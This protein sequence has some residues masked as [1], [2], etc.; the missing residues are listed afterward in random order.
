MRTFLRSRAVLVPGLVAL[1]LAACGRDDPAPTSTTETTSPGAP[2]APALSPAAPDPDEPTDPNATSRWY[3]LV[4]NGEKVGFLHVVWRPSTWNGKPTVHDTTRQVT[5][6]A[7]KMDRVED[8]FVVES[9]SDLER[10][11]DGTYW[12]SRSVTTEGARES[13]TEVTWTGDGYDQVAKVGDGEQRRRVET[14]EPVSVDAETLVGPRVVAGVAKAGDRFDLRLLNFAGSRVDVHQVEV[15]GPAQ[16]PGLDGPVATT[17]VRERDPK[18][19]HETLLWIDEQGAIAQLK[20]LSTEIRRVSSAQAKRWPSKVASFSITLPAQPPL[21]R[22]FS[23]DETQIEVHVSPDADRPRPEFPESRFSRETSVEGSD[24]KGWVVRATLSDLDAPFATAT[25]PVEDERFAKHLEP[26]AFMPCAHPDV[27]GAAR[28]A[29]GD[30]TDARR[31]AAAISRFVFT[32]LHKASSDVAQATALEILEQQRGDCSE[33]ALLFVA[34]CRAVGVPARVC[35]GY[36]CVGELWGAH[37]WAEVWTG[38]WI[39]VDPT[40]DDVGTAARYLFFGYSDDP[41]SHP[42]IVTARARGRL[43]IVTTRVVEGAEE[44][45]LRDAGSHRV[46]DE[47]AGTASHRLAGIEMRGI[48][49]GWKVSLRGAGGATIRADGWTASVRVIADQG[50]RDLSRF[51]DGREIRFAGAKAVR[52]DTR[53]GVSIRASSRRRLV[54]VDVALRAGAEADEVVGALERVLAKTFALR[55]G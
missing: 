52:E 15:V 28:R 41:D 12:W 49:A 11:A 44:V 54:L 37:A 47:A 8:L 9:V 36:V 40:T 1:L 24:A 42:G 26:T 51:S 55:P 4:E 20:S 39:G 19:G 22:I 25:I 17:V 23:A 46:V 32:T 50:M 33:H 5:R 30:E 45:D 27:L 38:E 2:A 31:A 53:R 6:Q 10:S 34:L 3:D 48:P 14:K 16:V 18:T 21:E 7:R 35:S 13:T 43:R 29:V